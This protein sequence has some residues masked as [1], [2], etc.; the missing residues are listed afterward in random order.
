MIP[1]SEVL[2]TINSITG[3]LDKFKHYQSSYKKQRPNKKV[4][5][6][7][8]MAYGCN[9][10]VEKM[11]KVAR[12][13]TTTQLDNTANWYFDLENIYKASDTINNFMDKLELANLR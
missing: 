5:F 1:L 3:Y 7:G 12:S 8:L 2:A 11:A 4:F 13:V 10:G 9:I 6:A